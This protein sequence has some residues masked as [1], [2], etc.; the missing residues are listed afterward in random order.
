MVENST[1][2]ATDVSTATVSTLDPEAFKK[3]YPDAFYRKFI[4]SGIRPDGRAFGRARPTTIGLGA[5]ETADSSALVKIGSTTVLAGI[6][7]EVG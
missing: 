4:E 1:H 5:V 2:T 7:L 3:L 6:K